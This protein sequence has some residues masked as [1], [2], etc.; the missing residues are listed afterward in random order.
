MQSQANSIQEEPHKFCTFRCSI[1]SRR[2][3]LQNQREDVHPALT[4]SSS[5]E[6]L[7]EYLNTS[8]QKQGRYEVL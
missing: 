5:Q 7:G 8:Q 6:S 3:L 4:I 2:L 1:H